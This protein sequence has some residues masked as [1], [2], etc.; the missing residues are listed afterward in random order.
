M[1]VFYLNNK[2]LFPPVSL[3][4]ENGIIAV[5]GDLS[6]GR[7]IE[8]YKTGIFPWFS[9]GDPIIWWSPDP[10]FVLFPGELKISKSMKQELRR[11][12]FTITADKAFEQVIQECRKP[13]KHESGTW[14]TGEIVKG[15]TELHKEGFAHSVEAWRQGELVGGLYGVSLGGCFFGESMFSKE[16]NASKAA[17]IMLAEKLREL[18]FDLIDCQVYTAH[19]ESLGAVE[20]PREEFSAILKFSLE[21]E[22]IRGNWSENGLFNF[23]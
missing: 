4:E 9:E 12:T 7:L 11:R 21:R 18:D 23:S 10:R 22:T 3:A 1:P 2:D 17:F 20:I 5:G 8:A 6:P 14:I 15:Y 19:L 13:R 16:K